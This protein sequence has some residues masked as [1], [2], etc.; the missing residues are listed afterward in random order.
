MPLSRSNETLTSSK[1]YILFLLADCD[2]FSNAKIARILRKHPPTTFSELQG[3]LNK[4]LI[5]QNSENEY[6]I[7]SDG[8]DFLEKP[9][10]QTV[11]Y[12][13]LREH[14]KQLK[15]QPEPKGWNPR[16]SNIDRSITYF[17]S[18]L[19]YLF[20]KDEYLSN[21]K[22]ARIL[23]KQPPATYRELNSLVERNLLDKN[24]DGEYYLT[25][26]GID[27]IEKN[28]S[29]N[30]QCQKIQDFVHKLKSRYMLYSATA[31]FATLF[32]M[33]KTSEVS[34]VSTS[35]ETTSQISSETIPISTTSTISAKTKTGA[36]SNMSAS[37]KILV[38]VITALAIGG[39]TFGVVYTSSS[40]ALLEMENLVTLANNQYENKQYE[41]SFDTF[42]KVD[43]IFL[44]TEF[45][46]DHV[47]HAEYLHMQSLT[48]MGSSLHSQSNFGQIKSLSEKS[49]E[50]YLYAIALYEGK[51]D[52]ENAWLGRAL[53]NI[54][55][56]PATSVDYC[57]LFD[58]VNSH[59]C[60][61]EAYSYMYVTGKA[62]LE[63][64]EEQFE[65][66]LD[67]A[68]SKQ[69]KLKVQDDIGQI[70]K[71]YKLPSE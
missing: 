50:Y 6:F 21:A 27:L 11:Y 33:S 49:E 32:S 67:M 8:S 31:L 69:Q 30:I 28:V 47:E 64:A 39:G 65:M 16:Q 37:T 71:Y 1:L 10:Y 53:N 26:A 61:G 55:E 45:S 38:G 4:K 42:S 13:A 29:N 68:G 70:Y 62:P 59:M 57:S 15:E 17:Q 22:I 25:S 23:R 35:L 52:T 44:S 51:H 48:G 54:Y 14:V 2:L 7:T 12:E 66:A 43:R 3:L 60:Q 18:Q 46:P 63:K 34:A 5:Q 9:A 41:I 20:E 58:S 36:I 56:H 24:N 40:N 19:L